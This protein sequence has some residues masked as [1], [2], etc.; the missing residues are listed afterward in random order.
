MPIV[1]GGLKALSPKVSLRSAWDQEAQ[2]S[3]V[4][5]SPWATVLPLARSAI[6]R[7]L[8]RAAQHMPSRA[9]RT[10]E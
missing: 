7:F 2:G 6:G 9:S 3:T 5:E 10:I 4:A 1:G 8:R